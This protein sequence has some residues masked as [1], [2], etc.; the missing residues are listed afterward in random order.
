M[1]HLPT[2]KLKEQQLDL[3]CERLNILS[4]VISAHYHPREFSIKSATFDY[5][6]VGM[7]NRLWLYLLSSRFH[8]ASF[9]SVH[10]FSGTVLSAHFSI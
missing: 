10:V 4:S 8:S 2:Q 9:I 3:E 5:D 6:T 7:E 1:R